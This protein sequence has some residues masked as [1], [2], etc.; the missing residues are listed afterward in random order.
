MLNQLAELHEITEDYA[1]KPS[2]EKKNTSATDFF[3]LGVI[4]FDDLKNEYDIGNKEENII[5]TGEIPLQVNM[6]GENLNFGEDK[7][8]SLFTPLQKDRADASSIEAKDSE[9]RIESQKSETKYKLRADVLFKNVFRSL[10][11]NLLNKFKATTDFFKIKKKAWRKKC[12][13]QYIKDFIQNQLF[14]NS[15]PGAFS[16]V[17]VEELS[18][19]VGKIVLQEY[20]PKTYFTYDCMKYT[21]LYHKCIYNFNGKTANKLYS[22]K[23]FRIL[24]NYLTKSEEYNKMLES[25]STLSPYKEIYAEKMAEIIKAF[26]S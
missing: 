10:K 2:Y 8:L 1:S 17:S 25:D 7:D 26:N 6:E 9:S 24:F 14:A 3:S 21:D 16:E 22:S 12:S 13:Q 15:P 20:M 5:M 4:K 23:V 11:K 19:Y 18:W